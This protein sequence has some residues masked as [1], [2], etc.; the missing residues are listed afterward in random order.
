LLTGVSARKRRGAAGT[1]GTN[2]PEEEENLQAADIEHLNWCVFYND[3]RIAGIRSV[4]LRAVEAG[5]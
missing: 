4:P 1:A 5:I 3:H 2:S